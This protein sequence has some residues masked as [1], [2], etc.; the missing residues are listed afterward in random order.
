[1]DANLFAENLSAHSYEEL[2]PYEDQYVAWSMD[3]KQV[4]AHGR[5]LEDLYGEIDC[6]GLKEY[7]IGFVPPSGISDLGSAGL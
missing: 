5:E 3:G 2:A 7:V 1:V 4:L 6:L